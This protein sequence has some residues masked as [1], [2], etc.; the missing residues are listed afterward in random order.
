MSDEVNSQEPNLSR[1]SGRA[2]R[3]PHPCVHLEEEKRIAVRR[4]PDALPSK[5]SSADRTSPPWDAPWPAAS[6]FGRREASSTLERGRQPALRP[7]A[8]FDGD[9]GK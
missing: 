8:A 2:R 3:R 7:E 1:P 5:G 6:V 4:P 9:V